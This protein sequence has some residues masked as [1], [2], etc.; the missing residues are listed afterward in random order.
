MNVCVKAEKCIFH[1]R[2]LFYA[3]CIC[4]TFRF[5]QKMRCKMISHSFFYFDKPNVI[6]SSFSVKS[7]GA[8]EVATYTD[9]KEYFF[10]IVV[11]G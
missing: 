8:N 2:K 7:H 9:M 6:R 5:M 4:S 11:V 1:S 3:F 10:F